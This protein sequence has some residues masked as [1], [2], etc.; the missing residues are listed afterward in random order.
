[1]GTATR[2]LSRRASL[3]AL[4]L[5]P[6]SLALPPWQADAQIDRARAL[7]SRG[8]AVVY[9]RHGA[10]TRSGIDQ[11]DWRRSQQRLLSE[12]GIAQSEQIGAAF[13]A[14][15]FP[16]GEVIASPFARCRDMAEIAFGRAEERTEL[17]GLLSASEGRDVRV[18]YLR[19]K[20]SAPTDG[21]NRVIVAHRSNIAEVAGVVLGEGDGIVVAPAGTSFE[22]IATLHPTEW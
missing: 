20:L 16:V 10:T 4:G 12:L 6:V 7:L 11:I 1:M 15:G 5:V 14:H 17:L 22:L 21:H 18:H 3:V 8:E 2:R 19:Q 13:R 9:F